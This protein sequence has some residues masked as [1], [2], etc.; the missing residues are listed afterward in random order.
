MQKPKNQKHSGLPDYFTEAA[1]LPEMQRSF[2]FFP[3]GILCKQ[4]LELLY[5]IFTLFLSFLSV[6]IDFVCIHG[7]QQLT[8]QKINLSRRFCGVFAAD[9]SAPQRKR[10][11]IMAK[12]VMWVLDYQF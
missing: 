6:L 9:V 2:P 1:M 5:R 3:F 8:V 7:A 12:V 11:Y 10:R 4:Y